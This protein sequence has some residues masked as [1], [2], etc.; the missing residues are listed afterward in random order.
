[1]SDGCTKDSLIK[2]ISG[3]TSGR[4]DVAV[5][6][7]DVIEACAKQKRGKAVG[8]DGIAMEAFIYGGHRMYVHFCMLFDCFYFLR[9]AELGFSLFLFVLSV[10]LS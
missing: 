4:G 9:H 6:V 8:L 2:R 10:L 7:H 5:V 3:E 1:V